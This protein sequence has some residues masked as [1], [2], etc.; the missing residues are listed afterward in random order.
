MIASDLK[1]GRVVNSMSIYGDTYT[2]FSGHDMVCSFELP[3]P[4]GG[5]LFKIIGALQ[6]VTYSIHNEKTPVRCVGDMNPKGYVFGTRTIAGTLIFTVFNKHWA[7]E[8]ME[9]YLKNAEVDAHMLTDELPPFNITVSCANEYGAEARLAIYG[10]T[11]V[12]EGQVMS[13]NDVYT[14]N[15]YQFFATDVDYMTDVTNIAS[16]GSSGGRNNSLPPIVTPKGR[17]PDKPTPVE[18]PSYDDDKGSKPKVPDTD[19]LKPSS[20]A[21]DWPATEEEAMNEAQ[22]SYDERLKKIQ[23]DFTQGNINA[24]EARRQQLMLQRALKITQTAI[25]HHYEGELA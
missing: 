21:K 7:K 18:N 10:V 17:T 11:I 4:T 1:S 20:S 5:T 2:T 25:R 15:T 6:T 23:V 14:E 9:E 22:N 3:L 19:P 24:T 12:N 8:M 13:I 16:G